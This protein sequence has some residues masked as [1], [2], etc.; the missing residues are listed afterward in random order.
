VGQRHDI[1]LLTTTGRRSGE[2]RTTPLIFQPFGAAYLVV[3]SNGGAEQPPD[4]YLNLESHPTVRVQIKG[5]KFV[6]RARTAG[7]DERPDM[8]RVMNQIWPDYNRYQ[9]RTKREIP[10][11]VLERAA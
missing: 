1:L 10:V 7:P 9:K 2:P 6:A 8:W 3:A 5:D 4:W 11:V